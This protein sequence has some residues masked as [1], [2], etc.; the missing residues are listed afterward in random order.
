VDIVAAIAA[1]AG[2]ETAFTPLDELGGDQGAP[3]TEIRN[4]Y[5][6]DAAKAGAG[7]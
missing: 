3:I 4:S 7:A 6:K 2:K 5:A 1:F